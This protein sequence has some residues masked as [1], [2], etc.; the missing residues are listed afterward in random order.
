MIYR[1][2]ETKLVDDKTYEEVKNEMS[3]PEKKAF[4]NGYKAGIRCVDCNSDH[5]GSTE[6]GKQL[7]FVPGVMG[8]ANRKK[9]LD[10]LFAMAQESLVFCWDC[11]ERHRW[12]DR[13]ERMT[14]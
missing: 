2:P 5:F 3:W 14:S 1:T 11:Y 4:L 10:E 6:K 7:V 12:F 13:I 9:S 8:T